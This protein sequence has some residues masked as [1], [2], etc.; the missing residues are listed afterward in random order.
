MSEYFPLTE[1]QKRIWYSD[2]L[3]PNTAVSNVV[4]T[5]EF[6]DLD[7]DLMKKSIDLF[8]SNNEIIRVRLLKQHN[9]EP[10]QYISNEPLINTKVK[11]LSVFSESQLNS[12]LREQAKQP[13]S[14]YESNLYEFTIIKWHEKS[15]LLVKCHHIIIDGVSVDAL[16]LNIRDIYESLKSG[17]EINHLSK[18]TLH[19]Y[20]T[21]EKEYK[22]SSRYQKDYQ[23]WKSEFESIPEYLIEK[24]NEL[25]SRSLQANRMEFEVPGATK[26]L[27]EKFCQENQISIYTFFMSVLFIYFSRVEN[28]KDFVIGTY[29]ANRKS[30]ENDVLGMFVST[31]PFRMEMFNDMQTF[32]FINSVSKKQMKLMRHQKYP[33]NQLVQE[34]RKKGHD[35]NQLFTVGVEYQEMKADFHQIFSGYDFNGLNFHIKNYTLKKQLA[36]NIDYRTELFRGYEIEYLMQRLYTLIRDIIQF[37]EKSI[38]ELAICTKQEQHKILMDFNDTEMPYPKEKTIHCLFEEQVEK[39]PN[40]VA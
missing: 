9:Q 22:Q 37:P 32:E 29:L 26:I 16:L 30:K 27:I 31:L 6:K 2:A 35:I 7:D 12:W 39:D 33:Y 20:I 38:G 24:S 28:E 1:A 8:V 17:S 14:L 19:Q 15:L 4:I 13:I 18:Y 40:Q 5:V 3:F 25:Y 36:I 23:F 10:V 11:D 34:L 21:S